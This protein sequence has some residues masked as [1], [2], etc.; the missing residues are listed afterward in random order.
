[1]YNQLLD[2]ENTLVD[3]AHLKL[4]YITAGNKKENL[5][6]AKHIMIKSSEKLKIIYKTSLQGDKNNKWYT[7][8]DPVKRRPNSGD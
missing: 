4:S 1:M 8:F 2:F 3:V 6:K 7:W 5:N